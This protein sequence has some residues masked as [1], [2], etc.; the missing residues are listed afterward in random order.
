MAIASFYWFSALVREKSGG[1]VGTNDARYRGAGQ[2]RIVKSRRHGECGG[3]RVLH[4]PQRGKV[5]LF[6][7]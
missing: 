1:E 6:G 2:R 5:L 7:S 4:P 3:G